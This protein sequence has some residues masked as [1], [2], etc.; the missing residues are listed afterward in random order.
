[1]NGANE[2]DRINQIN[3]RMKRVW[4]VRTCCCSSLIMSRS[5][6]YCLRFS[7]ASR[8]DDPEDETDAAAFP[9]L[10][11]ALPLPLTLP[12]SRRVPPP[13]PGIGAA[14]A[15]PLRPAEAD[16]CIPPWPE[17]FAGCPIP[18]RTGPAEGAIRP[19]PAAIPVRSPITS[20]RRISRFCLSCRTVIFSACT[21]RSRSAISR[22]FASHFV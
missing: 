8:E 16:L 4:I 13:P 22:S 12:M 6:W 9:D 5:A 7:P 1:M 19:R 2:S 18:P 14:L 21:C 11:G 10:K 20:A 3:Q 15:A 17:G